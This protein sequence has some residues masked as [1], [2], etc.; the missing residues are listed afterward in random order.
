MTWWLGCFR[1]EHE[2]SEST[3]EFTINIYIYKYINIYIYIYT[4][5]HTYTYLFLSASLNYSDQVDLCISSWFFYLWKK[6]PIHLDQKNPKTCW[7]HCAETFPKTGC[8]ES[9]RENQSKKVLSFTWADKKMWV[10]ATLDTQPSKINIKQ[11]IAI[12]HWCTWH[13]ALDSRTMFNSW[14]RSL[15]P[16]KH[17]LRN[18]AKRLRVRVGKWEMCRPT[19]NNVKGILGQPTPISRN[20]P[21]STHL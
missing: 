17:D 21:V 11:N 3:L 1:K 12:L 2:L 16:C 19:W 8:R 10:R 20:Q 14:W 7:N 5:I 4:H 18:S 9:P 6:N 15:T 13:M